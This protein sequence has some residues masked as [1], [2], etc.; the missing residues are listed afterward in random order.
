MLFSLTRK[1]STCRLSKT[2]RES[3]LKPSKFKQN[4]Y[5]SISSATL[6]AGTKN[7]KN[8]STKRIRRILFFCGLV[9]ISIAI[10]LWTQ[11]DNNHV[12]R[13]IAI[14]NNHEE[15]EVDK[16][17]ISSTEE[18]S[19]LINTNYPDSLTDLE[20]TPIIKE[21]IARDYLYHT[22][23][24][25]E[26]L[27]SIMN[28][29]NFPAIHP[30]NIVRAENGEQFKNIRIG[31][32]IQFG[33]NPETS[34]LEEVRYP[35]SKL[36]TLVAYLGEET[37]VLT[38]D[39]SYDINIVTA[40]G[41]ISQSLFGAALNSGVDQNMIME[42][43]EVFGWDIDFERD[44]K[45]GDTFKF[46]YEQYVSNGEVLQNG[47]ILSAEFVNN[48]EKF[49]AIRYEDNDGNA[50]YYAPD[51]SSMKGTFLKSPMKFSRISSRFS[52]RRFHPILKK[53]RAHKGV[54]YAASRGTPI[55]TVA[56]GKVIFRGTKGGYG[57]TIIISHGGKYTT[58]YGHM[59]RYNKKARLGKY[60]KQGQTIGYVGSTGLSTGP[61]L[62]YEFRVNGVHRD[63]LTYKTPKAT[64]VKKSE[65]N[66]FS[67]VA[68]EQ[69]NLLSSIEIKADDKQLANNLQ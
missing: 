24:S 61:H 3:V 31:K 13:N 4:H 45:R 12:R 25:G 40:S 17:Q 23:K 8:T 28:K 67:A 36:L 69:L 15:T 62:H 47:N 58:L 2:H 48:G 54:D 41:T 51:G 68:N 60:V 16:S 52:K 55:R 42:L 53:W 33:I 21:E 19:T 37:T 34:E 49:V 57:R 44:I 26:S 29:Y 35:L 27:G 65:L 20:E 22:I 43:S 63:P 11:P 46:A 18:P 5:N 30:H 32:Q 56:D 10:Y 7:S 66:Q 64:S 59:H 6:N 50:S 14:D 39:V 38:E 9:S 1:H